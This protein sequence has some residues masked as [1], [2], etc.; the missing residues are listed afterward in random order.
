MS[1]NP[2]TIDINRLAI[3]AANLMESQKIT[4]VCVTEGKN[5]VG[6]L[7]IHDLLRLKVL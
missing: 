6:V 3:D 5:Q 2:I 7:H 4:F 1:S